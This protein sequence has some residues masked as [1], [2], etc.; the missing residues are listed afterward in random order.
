[1]Y[2]HGFPK[3]NILKL[4]LVRVSYILVCCALGE[5][6]FHAFAIVSLTF[7]ND[8]RNK[9]AKASKGKKKS[10]GWTPLHSNKKLKFYHIDLNHISNHDFSYQS[11]MHAL[12]CLCFSRL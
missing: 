6:K 4:N 7:L 9:M 2:L 8:T 12:L 5:I 3:R 10:T 11:L 1:M